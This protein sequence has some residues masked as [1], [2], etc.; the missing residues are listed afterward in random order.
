MTDKRITLGIRQHPVKA[1]MHAPAFITTTGDGFF[2][3]S[4]VSIVDLAGS[5]AE[6]ARGAIV[7]RRALERAT[8][9]KIALAPGV[10][11]AAMSDQPDIDEEDPE[12]DHEDAPVEQHDDIFQDVPDAE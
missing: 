1:E 9:L 10:P 8:G 3:E 11:A 5:K 2:E 6:A 12:E 4:T 7:I